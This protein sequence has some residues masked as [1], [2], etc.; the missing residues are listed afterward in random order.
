MLLADSPELTYSVVVETSPGVQTVIPIL[1]VSPTAAGTTSLVAGG[2]GILNAA[3]EGNTAGQGVTPDQLE[4]AR[5]FREDVQNSN[6]VT[7][8]QDGEIYAR[9]FSVTKY[10]RNAP[11]DIFALSFPL[12]ALSRGPS[13]RERMATIFL[14][15][16]IHENGGDILGSG[17]FMNVRYD[18]ATGGSDTARLH[19]AYDISAKPGTT[20]YAPM[21][22]IIT[23]IPLPYG[24]TSYGPSGTM[25]GV[26][27]TSSNGIMAQLFYVHP[28]P[29]I[30]E[31]LQN[32]NTAALVVHA[33]ETVIGE[34]QDVHSFYVEKGSTAAP[35]NHVHLQFVD[36]RGRSLDLTGARM[37]ESP[38]K[39]SSQN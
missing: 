14:G 4:K 6:N 36:S 24:M 28:N 13:S 21:S 29:E 32:G 16:P 23:G 9:Y 30:V 11:T 2:A 10:G 8:A 22:G 26:T 7:L 20:V 15:A 3:A 25:L 37:A 12:E 27:I 34:A 31:A 18:G 17:D 39:K 1:T 19:A 35:Q 5:K 33:G 38:K